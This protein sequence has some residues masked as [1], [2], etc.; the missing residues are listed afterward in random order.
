MTAVDFCNQPGD[1]I[2]QV[3]KCSVVVDIIVGQHIIQSCFRRVILLLGRERANEVLT[4]YTHMGN[5]KTAILQIIHFVGKSAVWDQNI[6]PLA[7]EEFEDVCHKGDPVI[8]LLLA[9]NICADALQ[10]ASAINILF[11]IPIKKCFAYVFD[12]IAIMR[13]QDFVSVSLKYHLD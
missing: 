10:Q 5:I 6:V 9:D 13:D 4:D 8:R 12:L 2:T 1:G 7:I 3:I 11:T